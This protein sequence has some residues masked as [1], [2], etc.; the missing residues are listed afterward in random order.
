MLRQSEAPFSSLDKPI[1]LTDMGQDE[2]KKSGVDFVISHNSETSLKM[3]CVSST[4]QM[5]VDITQMV[6]RKAR[7]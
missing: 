1:T 6:R 7:D 4:P 2:E 5:E 3:S